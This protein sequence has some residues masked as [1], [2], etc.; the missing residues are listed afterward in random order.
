MKPSGLPS[1]IT[2]QEQFIFHGSGPGPGVAGSLPSGFTSTSQCSPCQTILTPVP[3]PQTAGPVSPLSRED[4]V[5]SS[6]VY[7][8]SPPNMPGW[9]VASAGPQAHHTSLHCTLPEPMLLFGTN[10]VQVTR[11]QPLSPGQQGT[12]PSDQSLVGSVRL[13]Q[14]LGNRNE[15]KMQG[16]APR[17]S[18]CSSGRWTDTVLILTGMEIS[19][20]YERLG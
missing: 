7:A 8:P 16:R 9:Q 15:L 14:S 19:A 10:K 18:G 12:E 1:P 11:L 5:P 3:C 17:G 20:I 6:T 2:H 13:E 4:L